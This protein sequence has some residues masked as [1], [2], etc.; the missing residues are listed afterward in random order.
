MS[1]V[2]RLLKGLLTRLAYVRGSHLCVAP[3]P[4]RLQIYKKGRE[5]PNFFGKKWEK[6]Y[7]LPNF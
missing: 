1:Y 6:F 7:F 5:A 4:N 3:Y 2:A